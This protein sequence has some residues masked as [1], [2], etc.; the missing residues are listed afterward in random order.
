MLA[1][2]QVHILTAQVLAA[3]SH[4]FDF[5]GLSFVEAVRLPCPYPYSYP[6]PY[7][8]PYPTPNLNPSP[9]PNPT[10]TLFRWWCPRTSPR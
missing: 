5:H 6:D 3:Y 1:S 8:Y 9:N 10:P 2:A 4:A 7:P